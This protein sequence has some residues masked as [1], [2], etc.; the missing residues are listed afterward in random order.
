MFVLNQNIQAVKIVKNIF[1]I[2]VGVFLF[3]TVIAFA[4]NNDLIKK[5]KEKANNELVK[6]VNPIELNED[7]LTNVHENATQ[8]EAKFLSS[9]ISEYDVTKYPQFKGRI[10]SFTT[11]F[12]SNKGVADVTYS[13]EGRIIAVEKRLTNVVLPTQIQKV[14]SKRYENWTIVQNKYNVSYKAGFDVEK[15]YVI[16]IQQGNEKKRIRVNG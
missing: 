3:M 9:I 12:K 4:N 7:Y 5:K 14:V 10:K 2:T 11:I 1:K 8:K 13:A 15:S 16:T 6:I